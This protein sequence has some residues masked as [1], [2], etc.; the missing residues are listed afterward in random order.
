[1]KQRK[2]ATMLDARA[3]QKNLNPQ[4]NTVGKLTQLPFVGNRLLQTQV[5]QMSV[6]QL[7]HLL[8]QNPSNLLLID[9]RYQSEQ[10]IARLPGE[11][12]LVPYPQIK[13]GSGLAR[14]QKL[15][16]EKRRANPAGQEPQVLV[17]CKAGI[18]SAHTVLRLQQA[19]MDAT[20]ITGGI[21]AWNKDIDPSLPLYDIKDIPEFQS[22]LA[23]KPSQQ[24]R[25]LSSC[26]VALALSAVGAVGAVRY[27]SDLLRPLMK[28]G[29]PLAAA[30]DLPV[31]GYAIQEASEP[32]MNVQQL[33]QL[34]NGKEKDYLIVDVRTANEYKQSHLPGA[35]SLP[36]QDLEQG[37]G[38]KEI[39]SQL[40]G[41]KLIAYCTAGKRSA[42]ALILLHHAGVVGT[43]VQ[44]G[45]EAWTKEIDPS[46]A[47]HKG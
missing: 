40:Q 18:R 4:G 7:Q 34:V 30:S 32:I 22:S 43:K 47:A 10:N 1:V 6:K 31:V 44:G 14:I 27:N 19:G 8:A 17:L 26:G 36:L 12:F 21:H 45:L 2:K 20:N 25:W 24:Q 15:L 37:K 3:K 42:R 29:V 5:P 38:V 16:Q 35:V 13:A 9:V 23:K 33:K 28:A 46:L 41:R 11:W 39:K